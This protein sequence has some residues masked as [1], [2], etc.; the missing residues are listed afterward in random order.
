MFANTVLEAANIAIANLNGEGNQVDW[1]LEVQFK[2]GGSSPTDG[3][4]TV[5]IVLGESETTDLVAAE[6]E[7]LGE[8]AAMPFLKTVD[9]EAVDPETVRKK[10]AEALTRATSF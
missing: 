7:Q 6:L 3:Q 10:F 1:L 5:P 8:G 9:R 4:F 2:G